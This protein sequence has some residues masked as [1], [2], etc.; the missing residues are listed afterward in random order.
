MGALYDRLLAADAERKRRLEAMIADLE[1]GLAQDSLL[2]GELQAGD[3]TKSRIQAPRRSPE[4]DGR[5]D[6]GNHG[7]VR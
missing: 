5:A 2:S 1:E 6:D 7:L 4:E 3:E